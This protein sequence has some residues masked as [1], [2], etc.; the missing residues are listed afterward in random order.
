VLD[1]SPAAGEERQGGSRVTIV[2]GRLEAAATPTP[3]PTPTATP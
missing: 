1:Q 3:T 2:V